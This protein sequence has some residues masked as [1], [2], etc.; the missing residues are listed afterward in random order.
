[1][2]RKLSIGFEIECLVVGPHIPISNAGQCW[3]LIVD[4]INFTTLHMAKR[5]EGA[6]DPCEKRWIV[7][8]DISIHPK[9]MN[10]C[11]MELISPPLEDLPGMQIP[12]PS[13]GG[14]WEKAIEEV[15]EAVKK[16]D[17]ITLE[18]NESTA[19]HVHIG[20]GIQGT[21][22]IKHL[23]KIAL[24]FVLREGQMDMR[25]P[26]ERSDP[27]NVRT[28]RYIKSMRKS[29]TC[30]D[31][32]NEQLGHKILTATDWISLSELINPDSSWLSSY[33]RNYKVNFTAVGRHGTVEFRQHAGTAEATR[34]IEWGKTLLSLVR[35]AVR[36]DEDT[37]L[38]MCLSDITL[39]DLIGVAQQ[40]EKFLD[41]D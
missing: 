17:G 1:M 27:S 23:R 29:A 28:Q 39:V 4:T 18:T 30:R 6:Y 12:A 25:F 7:M 13:T 37:L 31:L 38:K 40:T 19:L 35:M 9:A 21:W 33:S 22:T 41:S 32:T 20:P 36:T 14:G 34:I 5:S 8:N 11:P 15:I 10:Q 24:L 16:I 3:Q 26:P 2:A